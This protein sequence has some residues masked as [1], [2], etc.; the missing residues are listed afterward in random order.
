MVPA[1]SQPAGF[2]NMGQPLHNELECPRRILQEIINH[3]GLV[4]GHAAGLQCPGSTGVDSRWID[5]ALNAKGVASP[6]MHGGFMAPGQ[7]NAAFQQ[8]VKTQ[9]V[10]TRGKEGGSL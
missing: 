8:D 2:Q 9:G 6:K 5:D 3:V 7:G 4:G 1:E 10:F